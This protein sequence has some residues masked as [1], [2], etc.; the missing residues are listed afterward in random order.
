MAKAIESVLGQTRPDFEFII[1]DDASN[2]GSFA[3]AQAY[4]ASDPRIRLFRSRRTLGVG[5][6]LAAAHKKARG[7]YIGYV[8]QDDW[9][10]PTALEET[11]AVLDANRRVGLVYTDYY[12]VCD[13]SMKLGSRTAMPFS[14]ENMLVWFMAF[15]FRLL[16]RRT[17][18]RAGGIRANFAHSADY[19]LCLRMSEVT[20]VAHLPRPLYYYRVH[21]GSASVRELSRARDTTARAVRD[22]LR[23]RGLD[24]KLRLRVN[25]TNGAFSLQPVNTRFPLIPIQGAKIRRMKTAKRSR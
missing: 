18:L 23:R 7:R 17:F 11:A 15:H 3:M 20:E 19:D 12:D 10:A 8:D 21:P 14:P 16:R 4:A 9:I 2:D 1:W 25:H 22:A 13:D 5:G 6:A 24:K